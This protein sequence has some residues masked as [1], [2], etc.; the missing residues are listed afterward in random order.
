M[1]VYVR[2]GLATT[3]DAQKLIVAFKWLLTDVD[4]VQILNVYAYAQ[5]V[6]NITL[7]DNF[8]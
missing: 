4:H 2:L 3:N 8:A 1:S 6:Q 5:N 7:Y